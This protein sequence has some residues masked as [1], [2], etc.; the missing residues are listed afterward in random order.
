MSLPPQHRPHTLTPSPP[1]G[2]GGRSGRVSIACWIAWRSPRR[3]NRSRARSRQPPHAAL[4]QGPGVLAGVHRGSGGL[5]D[6]RAARGEGES[7]G[8]DAGGAAPLV[9]GD[10]ANAGAF[11]ADAGR[12]AGLG[13]GSGG[14]GSPGKWVGGGGGG[15]GVGGE[16]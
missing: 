8:R 12:A 2:E 9:C 15:G 16:G 7:A 14:G 13:G 3:R 5:P 4:D 1:R 10:D 6:S 11:G